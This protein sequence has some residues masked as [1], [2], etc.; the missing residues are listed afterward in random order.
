MAWVTYVIHSPNIELRI[1][2][3]DPPSHKASSEVQPVTLPDEKAE[4]GRQGS[5][6]HRTSKFE[7]PNEAW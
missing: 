5:P 3:S 2:Y 7:A 1:S 4:K 6:Q